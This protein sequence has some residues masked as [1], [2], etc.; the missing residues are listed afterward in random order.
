MTLWMSQ[1]MIICFV[2]VRCAVAGAATVSVMVSFQTRLCARRRNRLREPIEGAG[3]LG[4]DLFALIGW[5]SNLERVDGRVEVPMRIV[6]REHDLVGTT[7]LLEDLV[8]VG[9]SVRLFDRLRGEPHMVC[10]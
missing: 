5:D 10:D 9:R 7:Q 2:G 8:Q 4:I 3:V 1:S 6:R